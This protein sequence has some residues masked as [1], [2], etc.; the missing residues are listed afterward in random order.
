[1]MLM[2]ASWPS[3]SEAAVTRRILFLALYSVCRRHSI[4]HGPSASPDLAL[5]RKGLLDA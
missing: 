1:M 3:K 2:A 4:G 5:G